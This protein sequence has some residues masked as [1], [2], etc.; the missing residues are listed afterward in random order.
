MAYVW[1]RAANQADPVLLGTGHIVGDDG[2]Q[3]PG[4]RAGQFAV[5]FQL[6]PACIADSIVVTDSRDGK[7]FLDDVTVIRC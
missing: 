7:A 2:T 4:I 5:S 1:C 3:P 6:P